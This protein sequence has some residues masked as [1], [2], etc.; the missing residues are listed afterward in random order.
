M[1]R[2][3]RRG[4]TYLKDGRYYGDFRDLENEKSYAIK[5]SYPS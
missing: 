5:R 2:K 3:R 4:R 1:P